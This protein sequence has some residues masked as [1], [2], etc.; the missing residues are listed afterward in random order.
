[1]TVFFRN[2][3]I[4]LGYETLASPHPVVPL[5]VRETE[6]TSEL[7]KFLF[8]NGVLATGLNFPIVPKGDQLIRFQVNA[9][10]TLHDLETVLAV[11]SVFKKKHWS[12]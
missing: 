12:K 6:K 4:S 1:M 3:L 2:G 5:L 8:E 10:H 7:V 9:S 11:L